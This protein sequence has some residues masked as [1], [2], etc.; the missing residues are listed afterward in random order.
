MNP[1]VMH[2]VS[3]DAFFTGMSALAL[4]GL[5][6]TFC[7]APWAKRVIFL[8]A[9]GGC[10]VVIMSAMPLAMLFYAT[11]IAL[12]SFWVVFVLPHC[13][14]G[15]KCRIGFGALVA[16]S[17]LIAAAAE[18]PR[19]KLPARPAGEFDRWYVIGDSIS[20]GIG[21]PDEL[22]WPRILHQR[23]RVNVVDLAQP[24]ATTASAVTQSQRISENNALIVVEIGGNDLLGTTPAKEFERDLDRLLTRA[25]RPGNAVLM[26]ELP[27]FPF[28]N[29]YG[30]AQRRLAAKHRV[31]LIPRHR[32]AKIIGR[33]DATVD[34]LHLS[35]KGHDLMAELIW[36]IAGS[37]LQQKSLQD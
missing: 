6:S 12:I 35:E 18:M 7:A 21:Q 31:A 22:T 16:L 19:R 30:R 26:F 9:T 32:F 10:S 37:A 36:E 1:L 13:A 20:A 2:F 29:A 17:C 34:G 8:L 11:W 25:A 5:L 28:Q 23:H 3:G 4:A 33:S 15:S 27:L 24:G 14:V